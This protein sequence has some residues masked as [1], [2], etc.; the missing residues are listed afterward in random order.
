VSPIRRGVEQGRPM[1]GQADGLPQEP[2]GAAGADGAD[3]GGATAADG[4]D[5]GGAAGAGGTR[6]A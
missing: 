3:S 1:P 5:S 6:G 2:G 4:A